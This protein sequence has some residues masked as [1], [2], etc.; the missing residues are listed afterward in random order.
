MKRRTYICPLCDGEGGS[1]CYDD[2]DEC[3]VCGNED[4]MPRWMLDADVYGEVTV[5]GLLR[6][7]RVPEGQI[8]KIKDPRRPV[9][10]KGKP[11]RAFRRWAYLIAME[12]ET[13]MRK[14]YPHDDEFF[15]PLTIQESRRDARRS[16]KRSIQNIATA[17]RR[18]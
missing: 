1:R 13:Y 3:E 9:M 16:A 6:Y 17:R 15:P 7:V 2:F 4:R 10:R 11:T 12:W 8:D 5:A 14:A 18:K